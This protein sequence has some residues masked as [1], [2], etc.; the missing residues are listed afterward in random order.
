MYLYKVLH[1]WNFKNSKIFVIPDTPRTKKSK[2]LLFVSGTKQWCLPILKNNA[3]PFEKIFYFDAVFAFEISSFS[4]KTCA[5]PKA[6]NLSYLSLF[7][8]YF[9]KKQGLEQFL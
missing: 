6:A 4:L 7:I 8:L 5:R 9:E 2:N 3:N 1:K